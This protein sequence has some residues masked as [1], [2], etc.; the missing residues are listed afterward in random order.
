MKRHVHSKQIA[1]FAAMAAEGYP[2]GRLV[3]W[4]GG[5][6][7]EGNEMWVTGAP[8]TGWHDGMIYRVAC[9]FGNRFPSLGGS[10]GRI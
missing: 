2:V 7:A 8:T 1:Q 4:M 10:H 9:A 6:R 5:N 3:Q